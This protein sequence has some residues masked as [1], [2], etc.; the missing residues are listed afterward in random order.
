MSLL[1]FKKLEHSRLATTKFCV[2]GPIASLRKKKSVAE[3]VEVGEECG[4]SFS[5]S[6]VEPQVGDIIQQ[7]TLAKKKIPWNPPGF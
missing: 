7:Q 5:D 4:L 2:S 1:R 6:S 3:T